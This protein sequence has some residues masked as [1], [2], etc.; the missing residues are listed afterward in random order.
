[1]DALPKQ[2]D[3]P[4]TVFIF[5]AGACYPDGV[6]L[7]HDLIPLILEER[8]PQLKGS[9]VSKKI[10]RFLTRNFSHGGKYPS[11][12][13]VFGFINFF[14]ANDMSLSGE[15][16]SGHAGIEKA[17]NRCQGRFL[18]EFSQQIQLRLLL[19]PEFRGNYCNA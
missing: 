3:K 2:N 16:N 9:R 15:R 1:M 11:L 13:E 8:D 7:Q 18:L 17:M 10:R 5:G 6:P 4:S 14:V 19:S 12:E